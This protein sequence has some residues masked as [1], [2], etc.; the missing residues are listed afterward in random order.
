M[1][2]RRSALLAVAAVSL[3]LL[4]VG[5]VRPPGA[6][7][8]SPIG[9]TWSGSETPMPR[10]WAPGTTTRTP[11]TAS[12]LRRPIR[13]STATGSAPR[14]RSSPARARR[15]ATSRTD[16]LGSLSGS[17]TDVT[18]TIGGN[19]IGFISVITECALP[20]WASHCFDAIDHAR[21]LMTKVLPGRLTTLYGDIS[22]R[23]PNA[24]Y[25]AVG[26]PHLF[27]G[28]DCNAG[29][30]FTAKEEAALNSAADLL[31]QVIHG[32]A[33]AAHF[34]FVDPRSAFTGHAVCDSD[35]WING[36]SFP[37]TESYHPNVAGPGGVRR[38]G[39]RTPLS[40]GG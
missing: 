24:T 33:T 5:G 8:G 36:L 7:R 27:N 19:D 34:S 10:G 15:P 39:R 13:C 26:Y 2:A 16:Q 23:A 18:I 30:F 20:S 35:E 38:P 9:R 21:D 17:T 37:V 31:D 3:G 22:H 32:R 14:S 25:V 11:A 40:A 28:D 6:G 1:A 12:G 4:T 29:T